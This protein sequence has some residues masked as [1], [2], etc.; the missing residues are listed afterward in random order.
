MSGEVSI[1]VCACST[2]AEAE[3][4]RVLSIPAP[5]APTPVLA[6]TAAIAVQPPPPCFLFSAGMTQVLSVP[7]RWGAIRT[8]PTSSEM[9]CG[10]AAARTRLV[11]NEQ[12]M[13]SASVGRSRIYACRE[14]RWRPAAMLQAPHL[15]CQGPVYDQ[16]FRE[17]WFRN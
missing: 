2:G 9:T 1:L 8:S 14:P 5:R 3:S 4:Q 10:D 12:N 6:V 17:P 11:S 15:E 7:G 16:P 13:E